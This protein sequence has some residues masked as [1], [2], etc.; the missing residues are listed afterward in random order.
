MNIQLRQLITLLFI[1]VT[2][3]QGG[4]W[5]TTTLQQMSLRKKVGQLFIA[6]VRPHIEQEF[7]KLS[8]SFHVDVLATT[9]EDYIEQVKYLI[10][11]YHVGGLIFMRGT[12]TLQV[13]LTEEFQQASSTPL[14]V[15]QDAEWG[16]AMRLT[17]LE[18]FPYQLTLGALSENDDN[19]LI[20]VGRAIGEQAK[21]LGVHLV[22]APVVDCNTNP[23]N[24]IINYRSFGEDP[25]RV[26][27]KAR[28]ILQGLF[29][30]GV[31]GC[32]K[33][34]PGHGD[35]GVDSHSLLPS[36]PHTRNRLEQ[37]EV[38]PFRDLAQIAPAI[39]T[40]H[41]VVP[42]LEEQ[43]GLPATLSRGI[44]H[45]V[46]RQE[47]GFDGLIVTDA[48][49]MDAV[50]KNF[51]ASEAALKALVAGADLIVMS[52]DI[53]KAIE[54]IVRE[55]E[56]DPE[57]L[58]R[59]NESAL[60]IL[61]AKESLEL[62]T[63]PST[64]PG[65]DP[66]MLEKHRHLTES[67]YERALTLID[68]SGS[69]TPL[70]T[71]TERVAIVSIN[72]GKNDEFVRLLSDST[73][74]DPFTYKSSDRAK[75]IEELRLFDRVVVAQHCLTQRPHLR[76]GVSIEAEEFVRKL[77]DMIPVEVVL[78]GSPY[79]L[80]YLGDAQSKLV[81]YED[82]PAAHRA[83]ARAL[84]GESKISGTLPITAKQ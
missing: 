32:L 62:S 37:V 5:A 38:K 15:S 28:C 16:T 81:A 6:D 2:T 23:Q 29:Q 58:A 82:V 14:L 66:A 70:N 42:C 41:L 77:S 75:L 3:L 43:P 55:A 11:D 59:V 79:A 18:R 80:Q 53:P 65:L 31:L 19:L 60:R 50:T 25:D 10:T 76:F 34:F 24:P 54:T 7:A 27:R 46:L 78:F 63:C 68:P 9:R 51:S 49:M 26:T 45:D 83:A 21:A 20:D 22:F 8:S 4:T 72:A 84:L 12:S 1:G 44:L 67:V 74:I 71:S 57:V 13:Q 69:F 73:D 52:P 48:M 56:K 17:D 47:M 40:G 61:E 35:T 64:P 33:H 36:I 30:S 39:M